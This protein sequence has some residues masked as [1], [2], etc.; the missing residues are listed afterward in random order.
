MN[1]ESLIEFLIS[2]KKEVTDECAHEEISWDDDTITNVELTVG[3]ID[4]ITE[5][6]S[7]YSDAIGDEDWDE[8]D[9]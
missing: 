3:E 5:I 4:Q 8:D 6:L 7:A 9:E 1:L 2:K